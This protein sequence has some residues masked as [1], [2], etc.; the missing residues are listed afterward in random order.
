MNHADNLLE[1]KNIS[2]SFPGVKALDDVSFSIKRGEVHSLCGENGA[3]KSTI[4]KILTSI[5]KQ[6]SGSV[7]LDGKEVAFN[8]VKDAQNAGINTVYQELNLIPYLSVAENIFL[9]YYPKNKFGID[10]KK[11]YEE[12]KKLLD[13][14]GLKIDPSA[15]LDSLGVAQQQTVAIARALSRNCKLLIMDEPTSSLDTAEV[16]LL[17]DAIKKLKNTGVSFIFVTHRLEE[18]YRICDRIT[19]LK[20][21]KYVG[22]YDV[23][24]IS[25]YELVAKMVGREITHQ[26]KEDYVVSADDPY[27]L[28]VRNLKRL[29]RVNDISF[30]VRRK[31]IV[32]LAGLLGSG[33]T[34]T[35]EMIF[36]SRPKDDGEVYV[37]GRLVNIKN[38]MDAVR[39]KLAFCTEN[40]R[41]DGI[42]PNMSVMNNIILTNLKNM[43]THGFIQMD[44]CEELVDE[45]IQKLQIKTPSRDQKIRNLSGGNQ[46]KALLAKWLATNPDLVIL[47]EP[48]RGID[49]GAKQEIEKMMQELAKEGVSVLFISSD[50]SELVRNCDRVVVLREG[51][52]VG[53]LSGQEITEEAIMKLIAKNTHNKEGEVCE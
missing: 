22:T 33:R 14:L 3:G 38:P 23:N 6:D 50:L 44:A 12:A 7:I 32:G 42:V 8:G 24:D 17:F 43:T 41:V 45:F 5:Y 53:E 34:E 26:R 10:W 27:V 18:I 19:I 11:L 2:I 47:D 25:Q 16:N 29:P 20:D 15:Q 9:N 28:E 30:G 52:D 40:R 39:N 13:E 31:E 49:V 4:I 21:G 37:H 51:Y 36:G 35:A 48:T 46:Q 1:V